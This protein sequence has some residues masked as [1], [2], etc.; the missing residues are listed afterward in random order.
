MCSLSSPSQSIGWLLTRTSQQSLSLCR[1]AFTTRGLTHTLNSLVRVS[2]RVERNQFFAPMPGRAS[3]LGRCDWTVKLQLTSE[4][5][6]G[7]LPTRRLSTMSTAFSSAASC[8]GRARQEATRVAGA[9]YHVTIS[10]SFVRSIL[11]LFSNFRPF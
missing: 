1:Q 6:R 8:S 5:C 2:R 7:H 9:L 3:R 10:Q 4:F 11:F